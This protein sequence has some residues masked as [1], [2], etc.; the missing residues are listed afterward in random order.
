MN[1]D[2]RNKK[3]IPLNIQLSYYD[4][5][6]LERIKK[7]T[8]KGMGTILRESIKAR[9]RMRFNNEPSCADCTACKCPQMH[10]IQAARQ[11]TDA[12]LLAQEVPDNGAPTE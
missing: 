5:E 3:S 7:E 4:K 2:Q 9:F 11:V 10:Q 6:M 8:G 1:T 12:E